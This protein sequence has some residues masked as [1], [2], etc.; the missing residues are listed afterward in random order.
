MNYFKAVMEAS[1]A[2]NIKYSVEEGIALAG[3]CVKFATN[4]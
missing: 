1:V 2:F 4:E 3:V